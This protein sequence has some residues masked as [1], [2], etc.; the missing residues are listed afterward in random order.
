MDSDPTGKELLMPTGFDFFGEK[1]H[2]SFQGHNE[3][4]LNN[5]ELLRKVMEDVGKFS[6]YEE[7]WWHYKFPPSDD[8]PLRDW[9]DKQH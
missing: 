1:A 6:L 2:H 9:E 5:R 7:E 8:Y 4:I 3:E